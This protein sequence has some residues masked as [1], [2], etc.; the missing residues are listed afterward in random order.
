MK[1]YYLTCMARSLEVHLTFFL[2]EK[3][4]MVDCLPIPMPAPHPNGVWTV[5]LEATSRQSK[6]NDSSVNHQ[7]TIFHIYGTVSQPNGPRNS[8]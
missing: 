2:L 7:R 4:S 8:V 6:Q 1:T 3:H 5:W